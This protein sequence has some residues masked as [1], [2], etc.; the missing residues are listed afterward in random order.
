MGRADRLTST[1]A[2]LLLCTPTQPTFPAFQHGS[3]HL[4]VVIAAHVINDKVSASA[5]ARP[6]SPRPPTHSVVDSF[7]FSSPAPAL[8]ASTSGA[9]GGVQFS[10]PEIVCGCLGDDGDD[11]RGVGRGLSGLASRLRWATSSVSASSLSALS[12][13]SGLQQQRR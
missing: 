11:D 7:L 8:V 5:L 4:S 12:I 13:W 9:V 3:R 6:S 1:D 2:R 10:G